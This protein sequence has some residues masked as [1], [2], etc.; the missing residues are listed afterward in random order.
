MVCWLGC[1][2]V[3]RLRVAAGDSRNG[4]DYNSRKPADSG[5]H[6]GGGEDQEESDEHEERHAK[7]AEKC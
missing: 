3:L 2:L 1:P 4:H 6:K 5:D 7:G